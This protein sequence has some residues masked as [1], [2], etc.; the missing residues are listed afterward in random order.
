MTGV[1]A[2]V[3]FVVDRNTYKHGKFMPGA[4]LPIRAPDALISELPSHVL[5]LAWNYAE[6]ILAQQAAY[7]SKGGRFI[8]PVP[9]PRIV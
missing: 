9:Q 3:D 6:E 4:H 2:E 8:I 7:R 5:L 1:G